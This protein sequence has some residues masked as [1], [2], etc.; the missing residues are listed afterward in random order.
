MMSRTP[1]FGSAVSAIALAALLGGC[2]TSA[3]RSPVLGGG[4]GA[5][6][7]LA[8]A[9]RAH[10]AIAAGD[11]ATAV[12]LAEQAVANSPSDATLRALLGNAYFGAGRFASAEAA[13]R[14]SLALA[15]NQPQLA[16]KLALVQIAQGKSAE[17]I[18]FLD[19]AHGFLD[20]ADHGLALALA[21]RPGDAVPML[22]QAARV[23]G[24][25][26]RVRQNLALAYGLA[27]DWTAARTVAEQDLPPDLVDAR[28]QQW[29]AFAKPVRASDQVA[30]L[31]GVTP[32]AVDPGQPIRLALRRPDEVRLAQAPAPVQPTE[33]QPA[34]LPRAQTASA[35]VA[36]Q[37]SVPPL[38]FEQ[39]AAAPVVAQA[40]LSP[41]P[42]SAQPAAP[43][44]PAPM[45]AAFQEPAVAD[46]LAA[47]EPTPRAAEFAQPPL[48]A[49]LAPVV[50]A[51]KR[52]E[53]R[54]SPRPGGNAN[55]VVQLGAYR[56]PA[57]VE[58][59]WG[60]V[61]ARFNALNSY[62]PASA[63]FDGPAGTVYRLSVRGFATV[64]E[65]SS[66]CVSLRAKGQPCFVR[67][68]AG[69]SPVRFASR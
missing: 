48:V 18:A 50:E 60:E 27:G 32:A 2:A 22:E 36:A 64:R 41:L 9:T 58:Y 31:L 38:P 65:A 29:M 12:G 7:K 45:T 23:P 49:A 13:Y 25:E 63:R 1:R 59:A 52:A 33:T 47:P 57:R 40:G 19:A 10:V 4:K 26:A 56:S 8:F 20:A 42:E 44:A 17:A 66:L 46:A 37:S 16:L 11:F 68:V 35:P 28:V 69:D 6:S 3:S 62:T 15:G 51:P 39:P 55:V 14:D 21:G 53:V 5:Q 30:G 24:A 34:P 54:K 61:A 43:Y 67:R